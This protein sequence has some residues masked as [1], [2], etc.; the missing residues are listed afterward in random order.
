MA[1]AQAW[2]R[3]PALLLLHARSAD[4]QRTGETAV[5]VA[6]SIRAHAARFDMTP[7]GPWKGEVKSS[8]FDDRRNSAAFIAIMRS[9]QSRFEDAGASEFLPR[10]RTQRAMMRKSLSIDLPREAE[11]NR[12]RLLGVFAECGSGAFPG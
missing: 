2:H 5:T 10:T 3:G 8:L 4:A 12:R 9:R 7:G 6:M 1:A 11:R